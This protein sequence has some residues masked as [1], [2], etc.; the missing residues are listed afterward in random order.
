MLI[1]EK[2]LRSVIRSIILES[3]SGPV[4]GRGRRDRQRAE[5]E[6]FMSSN[7]EF[8]SSRTSH[9]FI[10]DELMKD[11]NF[12]RDRD[13]RDGS[14]TFD[15]SSINYIDR[16]EERLE[17]GISPEFGETSFDEVFD[18]DDAELFDEDEDIFG[19]SDEADYEDDEAYED[20]GDKW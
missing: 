17:K 6:R 1:T 20:D 16:D 14:S 4:V 15:P 11:D 18:E 13:T 8:S 7:P 9:E 10:D 2:K 3:M 5:A 12:S 19:H